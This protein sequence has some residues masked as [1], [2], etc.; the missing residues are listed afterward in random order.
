MALTEKT[1]A[2]S[3][4]VA[5]ML[6]HLKGLKPPVSERKVRLLLCACVRP[7]AAHFNSLSRRAFETAEKY[8]EEPTE[9]LRKKMSDL[10]ASLGSSG[11][12]GGPAADDEAGWRAV[13]LVRALCYARVWEAVRGLLRG[14]EWEGRSP[15]SR[16]DTR[17]WCDL[18]R[19]VFGNPFRPVHAEP[20]WLDWNGGAVPRLACSLYD[21]RA[22]DQYPILADALEDAGCDNAELLS[23]LRGPGPH[24]RGCWAL[25]LCLEKGGGA[26]RGWKPRQRRPPGQFRRPVVAD[27]LFVQGERTQARQP[28]GV[29]QRPAAGRPQPVARH[30]GQH[31]V[32]QARQRRPRQRPRR[33]GRVPEP[34]AEPPEP[35]EQ[36]RAGQGLDGGRAEDVAQGQVRQAPGQGAGGQLAQPRQAEVAILEAQRADLRQP[37]PRQQPAQRRAR[38]Q[39]LEQQPVDVAPADRVGGDRGFEGAGQLLRVDVEAPQGAVGVVGPAGPGDGLDG[40]LAPPAGRRVRPPPAA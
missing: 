16:I 26:A 15:R 22:F 1:W 25:D 27:G 19:C 4:R 29:G 13:S 14:V 37:R 35:A 23:H 34:A 36:R 10:G 38:H 8:A 21:A 28:A 30:G 17:P 5:A 7:L 3:T 11:F 12:F 9:P 2:G 31:Q 18:V 20:A 32:V 24:D 39:S 6:E 40:L 33:L